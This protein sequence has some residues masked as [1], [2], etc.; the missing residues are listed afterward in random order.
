M[1]GGLQRGVNY[2][3][4]Q[5]GA[6]E[7]Q[8]SK[9]IDQ[10]LTLLLCPPPIGD[11]RLVNQA[12]ELCFGYVLGLARNRELFLKKGDPLSLLVNLPVDRCQQDGPFQGY[13]LC[14][15]GPDTCHDGGCPRS[16]HLFPKLYQFNYIPG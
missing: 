5:F 7:L 9:F 2:G 8:K 13:P 16:S 10:S 6:S 1:Q 11:D 12:R 3:Q 14:L 15:G 4:E